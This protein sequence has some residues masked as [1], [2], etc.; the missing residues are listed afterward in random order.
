MIR[1]V[2]CAAQTMQQ[3][4]LGAVLLCHVWRIQGKAGSAAASPARQAPLG[5]DMRR[6][7]VTCRPRGRLAR[8]LNGCAVCTHVRMIKRLQDECCGIVS[9]QAVL[10]GRQ[11]VGLHAAQLLLWQ[12]QASCWHAGMFTG[13]RLQ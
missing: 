1:V 12:M 8:R 2:S 10:G 3:H 4:V 5:G 6:A 11:W 7:I 9:A 13:T